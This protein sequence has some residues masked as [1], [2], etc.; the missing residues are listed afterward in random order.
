LEGFAGA[1]LFDSITINNFKLVKMAYHK[2]AL[3]TD[4]KFVSKL[5]LTI[6]QLGVDVEKIYNS[7][8][9]IEGAFSNG[10]IFILQTRP[11]V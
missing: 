2:N 8:Q 10:E 7:P 5:I 6:S 1:G 11:Q 9:D 3:F 4:E